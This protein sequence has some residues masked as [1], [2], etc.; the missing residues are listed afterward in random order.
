MNLS[1]NDPHEELDSNAGVIAVVAAPLI[2]ITFVDIFV[3]ALGL[4]KFLPTSLSRPVVGYGHLL[5]A[6]AVFWAVVLASRL[7][8]RGPVVGF[9]SLVLAYIVFTRFRGP[10]VW[11]GTFDWW[12][13][14]SAAPWLW[15]AFAGA[16]A[17]VA[18]S[19]CR[20]R[21]RP[22]DPQRPPQDFPFVVA[23]AVAA[24]ASLLSSLIW[25]YDSIFAPSLHLALGGC[26]IVMGIA[27]FA[28]V[29][30]EIQDWPKVPAQ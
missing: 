20:S 24:T 11:Q 28:F 1:R 2:A 12:N 21:V 4:G 30:N 15:S 29:R 17:G 9:C 6:P 3:L 7:G 22:A 5:F 18:W 23:L 10:W 13:Q 8:R 25:P 27:W 26:A 14:D 19:A 16:M